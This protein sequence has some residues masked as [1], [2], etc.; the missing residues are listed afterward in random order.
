MLSKK[1][2]ISNIKLSLKIDPIDLDKIEKECFPSKHP[3]ILKSERY[4]NYI[5]IDL[6]KPNKGK[7]N[8]V[9]WKKSRNSLKS[10]GKQHVNITSVKNKDQVYDSFHA[11][12]N[13]LQEFKFSENNPVLSYNCDTYTA[14]LDK[15]LKEKINL[16]KFLDLNK[17]NSLMEIEANSERTAFIEVN[18]NTVKFVIFHTGSINIFSRS[19]NLID[20]NLDYI[21]DRCRESRW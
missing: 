13:L 21:L 9:I 2:S 10:L 14:H 17:N 6:K 19:T 12:Q 4:P 8:Y 11:L 1:Y 5:S 3:N 7:Y 20:E 18:I 16:D 15:S